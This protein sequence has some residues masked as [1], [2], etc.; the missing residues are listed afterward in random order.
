[1][2]FNVKQL[3]QAPNPWPMAI[4]L[5]VTLLI[6]EGLIMVVW[7][8]TRAETIAFQDY[9]DLKT[10][11]TNQISAKEEDILEALDKA[12]AFESANKRLESDILVLKQ[13]IGRLIPPEQVPAQVRG[14][15]P[16]QTVN[17]IQALCDAS[18]NSVTREHVNALLS[19][20]VEIQTNSIINTALEAKDAARQSLYQH[21]QIVLS[22]ID[23]YTGPIQSDQASTLAAVKAYQEANSLKVDGKIG[24]NTF[25]TIV[26]AFQ[27]KRLSN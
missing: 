14:I 4:T 23:A 12:K 8:S 18:A 9:N 6:I 1:M 24:M 16:S 5:V 20:L 2:G 11:L 21:I 19:V 3:K 7:S 17:K 10:D 15:S 26:K 22:Q 27:E 13:K 25:I